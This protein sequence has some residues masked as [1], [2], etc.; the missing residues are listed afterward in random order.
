MVEMKACQSGQ[1]FQLDFSMAE[2]M[3]EIRVDMMVV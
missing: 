1:I 3:V 2:M